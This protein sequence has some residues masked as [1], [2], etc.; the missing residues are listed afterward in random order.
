MTNGGQRVLQNG[1]MLAMLAPSF[2]DTISHVYLQIWAIM[3]SDS[4]K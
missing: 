2:E 1:P 4:P 3:I